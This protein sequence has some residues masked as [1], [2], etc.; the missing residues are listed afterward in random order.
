MHSP[1]HCQYAASCSGNIVLLWVFRPQALIASYV[2]HHEVLPRPAVMPDVQRA[3]DSQQQRDVA[4]AAA[5][6]HARND[7]FA[8]NSY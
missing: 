3:L 2:M 6:K 4:E 1:L 7:L 5:Q 8:A